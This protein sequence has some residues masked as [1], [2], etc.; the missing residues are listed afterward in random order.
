MSFVKV[1]EWASGVGVEAGRA[2]LS[3]QDESEENEEKSAPPLAVGHED[4]EE[5][6]KQKPLPPTRETV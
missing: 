1:R 2:P 3:R 5:E 4:V 6:E